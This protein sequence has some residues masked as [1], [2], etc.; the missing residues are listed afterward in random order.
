MSDPVS[1]FVIE[2]GWKVIDA[3]DDDVGQVEEVIGDTGV[4]IFNGLAISTGLLGGARYVPAEAVGSITEGTVKLRL[5]A[6]EVK[7]LDPYDRPPP[8]EQILPG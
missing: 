7:Q 3:S 5:S 1:W 8:S 4:D 2:E 6:D